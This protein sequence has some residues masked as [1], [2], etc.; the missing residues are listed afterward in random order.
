MGA[1]NAIGPIAKSVALCFALAMPVA[2]A[3]TPSGPVNVTFAL[4]SVE[5]KYAINLPGFREMFRF[6][7]VGYAGCAIDLN[8]RADHPPG[9]TGVN[10]RVHL[11]FVV[12]LSSDATPFERQA[13]GSIERG[14]V[15]LYL[16]NRCSEIRRIGITRVIC[17]GGYK[18]EFSKL[19]CPYRF[20]KG[21][22]S[23]RNFY[24]RSGS[25]TL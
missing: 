23:V 14:S 17:F 1:L 22:F 25:G 21:K 4:A 13:V 20:G 7:D 2:H 10:R 3:A 6:L 5:D 18:G 9:E 16:Y 24:I 12:S 19:K 15:I 11:F 8:I